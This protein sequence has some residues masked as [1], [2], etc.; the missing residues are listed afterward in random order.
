MVL[1]RRPDDKDCDAPSWRWIFLV[2]FALLFIANVALMVVWCSSMSGMG[3]I[4]MPGDW[5]VSMMWIPMCGQTWLDA[6]ASFVAMWIVMMMAMMLPSLAWTSWH[7]E[8]DAIDLALLCLGY[9]SVWAF[10]GLTVFMVGTGLVAVAMR[11]SAFAQFMP[12][13]AG[14]SILLAGI[15]QFSAL[16]VHF[17]ADCRQVLR[18]APAFRQGLSLGSHCCCSC[19]GLT[20]VLLVFGMMDLRTMV[21]VTA[22]VTAERVVPAGMRIAHATGA[23]AIGAGALMIARAVAG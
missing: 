4:P 19:A 12:F 23:L 1:V 5:A 17:L 11:L 20:T 21:A 2:V 8:L 9:F 22:A 14:V 13:A 7:A 16:K 3:V 10:L 15:F 18:S 6:A